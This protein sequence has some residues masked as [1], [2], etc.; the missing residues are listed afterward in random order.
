MVHRPAGHERRS[1]LAD[2]A[3]DELTRLRT[4]LGRLLHRLGNR[5]GSPRGD[6]IQR[7]LDQ[8]FRCLLSAYGPY[9]FA[10]VT[11]GCRMRA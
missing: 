8:R 5:R 11:V 6:A 7:A 10:D 9:Y 3:H 4:G 1:K 2:P